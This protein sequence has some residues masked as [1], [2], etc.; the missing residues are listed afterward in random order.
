M[1]S[2]KNLLIRLALPTRRECDEPAVWAKRTEAAGPERGFLQPAP[3]LIL[4]LAPLLVVS[5]AGRAPTL[6]ASPEATEARGRAIPDPV[7][8]FR[9]SDKIRLRVYAEL[10]PTLL[11]FGFTPGGRAGTKIE[12]EVGELRRTGIDDRTTFETMDLDL[13]GAGDHTAR[14]RQKVVVTP[15]F[16]DAQ[17]V[18][19]TFGHP[20]LQ[21][22]VWNLRLSGGD[23]LIDSGRVISSRQS[24]PG[25]DVSHGSDA[26]VEVEATGSEP[27]TDQGTG[28]D[29][30]SG[31]TPPTT[32]D[33]DTPVATAVSLHNCLPVYGNTGVPI[34]SVIE[35]TGDCGAI[36]TSDPEGAAGTGEEAQPSPA[37][38]AEVAYDQMLTLAPGVSIATAP[39]AAMTG[40]PTFLW[41]DPPP[42]PISAAASIPG[43]TVEARAEP[44]SFMWDLGDGSS[45]TTESP[46]RP[47]TRRSDGDVRHTYERRG[48]YILS[49]T[50]F[51]EASW[52][53]DGGPWMSL[54][55]FRTSGEREQRVRQMIAILS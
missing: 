49:V 2:R 8:G 16:I 30:S 38:L 17:G 5:L 7:A 18:D 52:R 31:S 12:G 6:H 19:V 54:G 10:D 48:R 15:S 41:L 28:S 1:G 44:T 36:S 23:W 47:W 33:E 46:G 43:L 35:S 11:R 3:V 53:V 14:V 27:G 34:D 39:R 45:M 25:A 51:W 37:D 29:E 42:E 21:V 24:E 40:L 32:T 55:S 4:L 9:A 26:G 50:V 13:L 20:Q 22:I